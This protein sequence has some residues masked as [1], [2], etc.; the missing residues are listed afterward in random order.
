MNLD[1][2]EQ[3]LPVFEALASK[4]RMKIIHLLAEQPRNVKELAQSLELTSAIM[5][6]HVK[7]L[8]K[9]GIIQSELVSGRGGLQKKCYLVTEK[10][11]V[12]FP[13]KERE[14]KKFHETEVSVGHYTDF[15]IEPTCGIAT[16]D[17]IIG[18][19]DDPRY[20]LYPNRMNAKI[21]WFGKGYVEYK[22]PN[23]LLGNQDPSE[24]E[25]SLELSSEAPFTNSNWPS[26]IHFYLNNVLLGK[27]T[28]PGDFGDS[29]G[30]FTPDW[31]PSEINQYGLLKRLRIT[32][33]GTYI[34]GLKISDVSLDDVSIRE[35]QWTFRI[36]VLEESQNVGGVTLFGTGFG[37]YNQDILFRL[38]YHDSELSKE[39]TEKLSY[40]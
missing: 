33:E 14:L 27:W 24:L 30:N 6:M 8:E 32:P 37:N 9:A 18:E 1:I 10:M 34:D 26:D 35:K 23:F 13:T 29:R 5:T 16:T 20:F 3:S 28:S 39:E 25:I 31:W 38:Y 21:L 4:V 17:T 36:A 19:F 2:S 22:M 11:E 12:L 40:Q 7:K 15:S